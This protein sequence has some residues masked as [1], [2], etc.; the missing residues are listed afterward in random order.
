MSKFSKAFCVTILAF[1]GLNLLSWLFLSSFAEGGHQQAGF[2]ITF[3]RSHSNSGDVRWFRFALDTA[4][5]A[6]TAYRIAR[7][8]EDYDQPDYLAG[9]KT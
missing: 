2:P 1:V 5:A 8:W 7:W 3:W 9:K 4:I 6:T